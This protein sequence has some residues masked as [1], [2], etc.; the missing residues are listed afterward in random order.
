MRKKLILP[1]LSL[2][3][4]TASLFACGETIPSTSVQESQTPSV[5][6]SSP[7]FSGVVHVH[8]YDGYQIDGDTHY[9]KCT[10]MN[11]TYETEHTK[12][13][14][15]QEVY[16]P[17]AFKSEATCEQ[18]AQFY[19]S[20]ICG[21][22]STTETFSYGTKLDHSSAGEFK[23]DATHHWKECDCGEV[24]GK[25]EHELL[26]I[27][28]VADCVTDGGKYQLCNEC[29]WT[30]PVEQ[31]ENYVPA[32]GHQLSDQ[33]TLASF[34]SNSSEGILSF[35]CLRE[36]CKSGLRV[37]LPLAT[38]DNY[39]F[40]KNGDNFTATLTEEAITTLAAKYTEIEDLATRL[41]GHVFET[42]AAKVG[43]PYTFKIN[44]KQVLPNVPAEQDTNNNHLSVI[45]AL[46]AGDVLEVYN[47]GSI[48][49]FVPTEW[50]TIASGTQYTATSSAVMKLHISKDGG[51]YG[52]TLN[53][54]PFDS[55]TIKVNGV[56]KADALVEASGSDFARFELELTEGDVVTFYGDGN[57]LSGGVVANAEEG[58]KAFS[59]GTH[60]FYVNNLNQI[61]VTAPE[62][63]EVIEVTYYYYNTL[64]WESVNCYSW[65]NMG[66]TTGNLA[67][68]WPGT[69]M[70]PVADKEGWYTLTVDLSAAATQVNVIFNA[71]GTDA[72]KTADITVLTNIAEVAEGYYF[73]GKS[74]TVYTS[75]EEVEEAVNNYVPPKVGVWGV[76]GSGFT[77]SDWG[78]DVWMEETTAGVYEATISSTKS[79]EFKIRKNAD[80][81]ENYGGTFNNGK[82]EGTQDGS[83]IALPAGT[84]KITFDET[85]HLITVTPVTNQDPDPNPGTS[86]SSSDNPSVDPSDDPSVDPTPTPDPED[87]TVIYYYNSNG[88]T[89]VNAYIW[90]SEPVVAWPGSAMTPVDGKPG[91]YSIE[92]DTND[93]TAYN[94]IF[95]NKVG[96]SGSQTSDIKLYNGLTYFYGFSTTGYASEAEALAALDVAPVASNYSLAGSMQGWA[97]GAT[98][99]YVSADA[100]IVTL[101]IEL[102]AGTHEFKIA[103][104]NSWDVSYGNSGTIEDTTGEYWWKMDSS[105]NCK[106]NA[107]GGTYLFQY[108]ISTNEIHVSLVTE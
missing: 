2:I 29:G 37:G 43:Y 93:L 26:D 84:Y 5:E 6:D 35:A 62:L 103:K 72:N 55:Y 96:D 98:P 12:H 14:Y 1:A 56:E 27:V 40:V 38:E 7:I 94:I 58:Y 23:T 19:K 41:T 44:Q 20:C 59:T 106:I 87:G 66:A 74:T 3:L 33:M 51:L 24:H 69:E 48:V 25:V 54:L 15:D 11:C 107:S 13:V 61:Y 9:Q 100:N 21:V 10:Y 53:V 64:G 75:F 71:D 70:E 32:F 85:T 92:I 104:D 42:T 99:F 73:F 49:S 45:L 47:N 30:T 18:A 83:N 65:Y 57:A 8:K 22:I 77:S 36:G 91:W 16:T 76:V 90:S 80:W 63:S 102:T 78:T 68:G 46:K 31:R 39:T 95:N 82:V 108:N 97:P 50:G 86:D 88:W 4:S 89:N 52:E 67:S 28:D 101:T 79:I 60:T 34:P 81:A 17:A 105:S